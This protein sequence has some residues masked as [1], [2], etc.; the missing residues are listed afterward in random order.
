MYF[1]KESVTLS[2]HKE[3]PTCDSL[4]MV[5]QEALSASGEIVS[6]CPSPDAEFT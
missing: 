6:F 1:L 3:I 2:W 4:T 5:L